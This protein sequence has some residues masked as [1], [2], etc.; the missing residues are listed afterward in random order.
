MLSVC[1]V[2]GLNFWKKRLDFYLPDENSAIECQGVQH[3]YKYGAKD[4]D[5][6]N[7]QK[8]DEDKYN[9]C[10]ANGIEV[11]YFMSD[12]IPVPE[13]IKAKHTYITDLKELLERIKER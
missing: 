3:F 11:L 8:R 12:M 1:I 2:Q 10:Q 13:E 7:R 4:K 9:E 6:K 5:L